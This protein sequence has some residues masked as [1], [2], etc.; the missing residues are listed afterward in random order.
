MLLMDT[1]NCLDV[2]KEWLAGAIDMHVHAAPDCASRKYTDAELARQYHQAGMGGFVSKCHHADTSGR[3]AVIRELM[4]PQEAGMV[5]GSVVF[6][7]SVGGLNPSAVM[8]C[9]RMGGKV[10][11]FPTIDAANDAIYKRKH[12]NPALG[13]CNEQPSDQKKITILAE[14]G[15]LRP[16][17]YPVLEA[18]RQQDL[19][20][21]TGHL[22]PQ[23]S[24]VLI[25]EAAAMGVQKLLVTHVSL[26]ITKAAAEMQQDFL[27]AGAWLEHC[28][29]TPYYQ[30][31]SGDEILASIRLAGAEHIILSTDFGQCQSP[32][33]A[34]GLRQFAQELYRRG[35]SGQEIR[36]MMVENPRGLLA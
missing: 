4:P 25:R 7:H 17:V 35:I 11:W 33:P 6:N 9:G 28:F 12:R 8:T 31:A 10:V 23:E 26:P 2:L 30:L 34:E 24:L 15:S 1:K 14:D 20:L 36:Q 29:Y 27:D 21:A 32:D 22:A 16:E 19:V 5:Y 3:A 18:I 13:Q